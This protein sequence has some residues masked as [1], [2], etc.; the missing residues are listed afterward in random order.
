MCGFQLQIVSAH[1][2][3]RGESE[4]NNEVCRKRTANPFTISGDNVQ[5]ARKE[6]CTIAAR[7]EK[8]PSPHSLL[9]QP[10]GRSLRKESGV[11]QHLSDVTIGLR[12]FP[13]GT[14]PLIG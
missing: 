4:N 9:Q 5:C 3:D 14:V 7:V 2:V 13:I 1:E 11:A 12:N 10:I 6:P 8:K